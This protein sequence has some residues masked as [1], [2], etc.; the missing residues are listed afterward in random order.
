MICMKKS[1]SLTLFAIATLINSAISQE[2]N[3]VIN[4]PK[5][6]EEI[7]IGFCDKSGLEAGIFSPFFAEEYS[8]YQQSTEILQ[9]ESKKLSQIRITIVM[10]SWCGDSK[11]QVPRFYKI[12]DHIGFEQDRVVL[13]SVDRNKN[14][15]DVPV[16][17]YKI[18]RVPTFIFYKGDKEVGRII[19]TPTKTLEDDFLK[20]LNQA[21]LN[22][23]G[24]DYPQ[25]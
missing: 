9:Q 23:D 4:D 2:L 5:S 19:E 18:E 13:I 1:L 11:E 17:S 22:D 15:H 16:E 6:V 20:I 24:T 21:F 25:K 10:G 8:R 14:G 7:L 3:R 12:L